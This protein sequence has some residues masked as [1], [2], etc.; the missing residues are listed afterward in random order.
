MSAF[1]KAAAALKK[2]AGNVSGSVSSGSEK[3]GSPT[4]AG[5]DKKAA[6][7][8]GDMRKKAATSAILGKI[9]NV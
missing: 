6:P 3:Q 4:A 1:N 9:I 7:K 8:W 5:E 2:A